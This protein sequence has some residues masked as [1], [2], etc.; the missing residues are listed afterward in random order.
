MLAGGAKVEAF[1]SEVKVDTSGQ[2]KPWLVYSLE[3]TPKPDYGDGKALMRIAFADALKKESFAV[4]KLKGEYQDYEGFKNTMMVLNDSK[5]LRQHYIDYGAERRE[6]DLNYWAKAA[7]QPHIE[8]KGHLFV[9]DLRFNNEHEY[10][11]KTFSRTASTRLFRSDVAIP[12]A[13]VQSEHEL[14]WL[15]TDY[16]LLTTPE[17]FESALKHFPQYKDYK[18][19]WVIVPA[20]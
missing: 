6:Q 18:L 13:D 1:D 20:T 4:L 9:T 16:L 19:R 10:A 3:A 12:P 14:D 8:H 17:D 5:L 11:C 2:V 15:Q 7:L